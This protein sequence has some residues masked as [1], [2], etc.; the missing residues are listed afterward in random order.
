MNCSSEEIGYEFIREKREH[1][2]DPAMPFFPMC[3]S[4]RL[5][6]S[7]GLQL[8]RG[9]WDFDVATA[10]EP[11]KEELFEKVLR[12]QQLF[13]DMAVVLDYPTEGVLKKT[14]ES[15]RECADFQI[16]SMAYFEKHRDP[17]SDTLFLN[18][19]QGDTHEDRE[20]HYEATKQF[21][22]TSGVCISF[23]AYGEDFGSVIYWIWR[24]LK[25]KYLSPGGR[26]HV[27]F[28]GVGHLR[29]AVAFTRIQQAVRRHWNFPEFTITFDSSTPFML[30]GR[31]NK[32][33]GDAIITRNEIRLPLY[34]PI[35]QLSNVS[36]DMGFPAR[37]GPIHTQTS[38]S[39]YFQDASEDGAAR[40]VDPLGYQLLMA[41]NVYA[42]IKAIHSINHKANL[43]ILHP[44]IIAD[45]PP[46]IF[47]LDD[48]V[49][50][51]FGALNEDVLHSILGDNFE[52]L[53]Y[54]GGKQFKPRDAI[55]DEDFDPSY[56]DLEE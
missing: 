31:F 22:F 19:L 15:A 47:E 17:N 6:D 34:G 43:A 32:A 36:N 28:L 26:F 54:F 53:S 46:Q 16:E 8:A 12:N 51:A 11:Q 49:N 23:R 42:T 4:Y 41:G 25:E 3:E 14:I 33:V 45:I 50:R 2:G 29:A 44:D 21:E 10:T 52:A 40:V 38:V 13:A 35:S 55:S 7:G 30:A 5:A 18:V 39:D 48:A 1:F 37:C 20:H 27:H 24:M 9:Q 56:M